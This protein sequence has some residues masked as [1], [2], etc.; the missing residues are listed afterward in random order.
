MQRTGP[1]IS[2][3]Q[4]ALLREARFGVSRSPGSLENHGDGVNTPVQLAT[5]GGKV[6]GGLRDHVETQENGGKRD[7]PRA[8][9][10]SSRSS[11]FFVE[12][13]EC[14]FSPS[15]LVSLAC[16]SRRGATWHEL[17]KEAGAWPIGLEYHH[18]HGRTAK[19]AHRKIR[20][21]IMKLRE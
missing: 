15:C 9:R 18:C 2:F 19:Q 10:S 5:E 21:G 8:L 12:L 3:S 1:R 14:L 4:V 20:S 7:W 16:C 6:A 17:S 13:L 11:I